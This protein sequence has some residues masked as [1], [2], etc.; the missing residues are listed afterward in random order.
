MTDNK[1]SLESTLKSSDT[2]EFID[3]YFYRPIGYRWALFFNKLGVTPN[4]IT[5][6][7]IF[8]GVAAGICYYFD[9]NWI[10][11]VGIFLLIWANSYDSAD[12]QLAR[13][14]GQ[15]SELGR[16][17]DGASGNFWFVS[18]YL[19]IVF[20][21]QPDWDWWILALAL[22]S[23]Y[24]HSK[25]AGMAD[26]YRNVHLLFLKGKSESELDN[27]KDLKEKFQEI[28]WIKKP[29][30]KLFEASYIFYTKGQERWSP[31]L[32]KMLK[33]LSEKYPAQTPD[34]F[35]SEFREKSLPLMKYTNMLSF[36]TRAIALFISLLIKMPWLYF[37]FELTVLNIMLVYMVYRHESICKN[38]TRKLLEEPVNC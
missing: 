22:V 7:S 9:N 28:S 16:I 13:M 19:A 26:Y 24:F 33:V 31:H 18:I 35:R 6:A 12:G 23:G 27:S 21:L 11:V 8:I 34:W 30:V 1:P 36:N 37:I 4:Q 3:I 25:Q 17:L 2:E 15:K 29:F 20:R 14:T 38:F 5:I 10:N 32:Q